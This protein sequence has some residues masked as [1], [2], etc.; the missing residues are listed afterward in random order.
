M[1][2]IQYRAGTEADITPAVEVFTESLGDLASRFHIT[3]PPVDRAAWEPAYHH[4]LNT[5]IFRVAELDECI[6]AHCM[7]IVRD[8]LCFLSAFWTRPTL[9]QQKIGQPLLKQVM[10]EGRAQGARVFCV[11]STIDPGSVACY[12]KQG[13]FPGHQLLVFSGTPSGIPEMPMAYKLESLQSEVA[14]RLDRD[15]RGTAREV[16]HAYLRMQKDD[17]DFAW[18]VLWNDT[19]VGYFY[20]GANNVGPAAWSAD[21]HAQAVLTA[22]LRQCSAR[23]ET[24]RLVIPGTNHAGI[25]FALQCGLRLM[26]TPHF[27]TTEPFG[28]LDRY[29]ATGPTLF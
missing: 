27:L 13:M 14:H 12:M 11:W 21:E 23:N 9:Q 8:D 17:N 6:A 26:L 5:G 25:R 15:V 16:D 3:M 10:E 24:V 18:Q 7:A 28:H 19:P 2:G 20:I 22:A 29:I 1:S 4:V